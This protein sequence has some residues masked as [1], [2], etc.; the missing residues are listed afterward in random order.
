MMKGWVKGR[1]WAVAALAGIAFLP[2]TACRASVGA[3]PT[4][5]QVTAPLTSGALSPE[6]LAPVR[7]Y[8]AA[9]WATLTRS[10]QQLP[11]AASDPKFPPAEP[12]KPL[13][14]YIAATEDRAAVAGT[15]ARAL[16]PARAA[17]I[18][19]RVLPPRP[20]TNLPP[21]L[22][23]LPRPYVVPGGRFNEMYG[24]DSYFIV[25]GLLRDG[26]VTLARD[27]TDNFL[28]EVEHYGK[29]LNANRSY[30]LSRSQ[31]PLIS[32]MVRAVFAAT[33]DRAWLAK[34]VPALEATHK[35]WTSPPH[36]AGDTGL[37]RY[38][39]TGTGPAPEVESDERDGKGR[40]HYQRAREYYETQTVDAYDV[41]VYFDRNRRVLT[42]QFYVGDRSMRESGFDPS[43]RWGPFNVDVTNHAPVCLN[44]LLAVLEQDL[45]EIGRILG[46]PEAVARWEKALME[47]RTRIDRYLWDPPAGMYFDWNFARGMRRVY[48]FA[49]TFWPLWA[50]LA[51]PTQAMR[52]QAEL[53]RFERP[54]GIRT[55]D[56]ETGNQWDAP[57]GWA[58]LQLF[59]ALGLKRYGFEADARRIA[60]AFLSMVVEDFER[61]E[62]I[63][64]KYD[65]ER[66]NSQVE[67]RIQFGY[68]DNQ[69]GFG[70]TNGV[71][72][73]LL[74]TFFPDGT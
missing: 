68:A 16:P 64:E 36:L 65:V 26:Q 15:I 69:I 31:P 70:W 62:T 1:I 42:P 45:A 57:F 18:E 24:W 48:P 23:Y 52:V 19:L 41:D 27:Q 59:A 2:L 22:L 5:P 17:L 4:S 74:A 43:E 8:I 51:S 44:V 32:A 28:Y 33:R 13:P 10:H 30:Y 54:G 66:R 47:R 72:L 7:S 29:V 9:A 25:L 73:E 63:L 71:F 34:A 35:F 67:A 37:S 12:G 20:S 39:D 40:T 21:G 61:R 53:P 58:P 11:E 3:P 60:D 46:D 55:S 49:T 56:R 38:F 50:G 6:H 14:V